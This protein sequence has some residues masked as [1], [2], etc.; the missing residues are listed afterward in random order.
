MSINHVVTAMDLALPPVKKLILIY[1]ANE[2]RDDYPYPE[3][4][5]SCIADFLDMK[6]HK[7]GYWPSDIES[8]K[9]HI[10]DMCATGILDVGEP[11]DD[12]HTMIIGMRY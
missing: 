3:F 9:T 6:P 1:I 5:L 7:D 4:H 8:I 2:Y 10:A 11:T 12:E